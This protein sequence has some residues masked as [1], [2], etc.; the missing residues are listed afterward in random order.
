MTKANNVLREISVAMLEFEMVIQYL[1]WGNVKEAMKRARI[2]YT[3]SAQA[4]KEAEKL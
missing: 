2:G 1:R 3:Y 4:V